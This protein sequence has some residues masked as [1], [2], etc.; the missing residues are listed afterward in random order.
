[1]IHLH[2]YLESAAARHGARDAVRESGGGSITYDGLHRLSDALRD[3]L[4]AMGVSPGDRVGVCIPKSIDTVAAIHGVLKSGGAYVPVDPHAPASRDAYI[5]S[6]CATKVVIVERSR[7][8]DLGQEMANLGHEPHLLVVDTAPAGQG[9]AIALATLTEQSPAPEAATH[10]PGPHDLAYI[11]Y[12]SGSTGKPK[13]VMISHRNA[14]SFVDWC[15]EEF[16]PVPDDVF[17]SHAPFHFDLSILD[18]YTPQTGGSALVLIPEDVGKSPGLLAELIADE[19]ITVWYSVPSILSMLA[20][21]GKLEQFDYSKVRIILFAGEVFAMAHLRA[22]KSLV[23]HPTY[24]NLYGPTE[25]NVCTFYRLPDELPADRTDPFPIGG[26]CPHLRGRVVDEN[27]V[28]VERG[29]EGELCMDGESVLLGYWNLPERTASAFL[30]DTGNV[31]W[32]RT[33]D[34]VTED[35]HGCYTYVGRRDRMVKKRGYRVELGEIES[36]LYGHPNVAEA[37]VVAVQDEEEGVRVIAHLAPKSECKLSVIAMKGYC[38][39]GLPMYMVPDIFRF[40]E[41]LPKT[42]TDKIDYQTLAREA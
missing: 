6:D 19:G 15:C 4:V 30:P 40:H 33:G 7:E 2:G 42:S 28:D 5:L 29:A 37:A 11:L 38:S 22:L 17:S 25:T 27:G 18:L 10:V 9:L 8:A 35:E 41:V 16:A 1:L 13:G 39:K 34:L 32:Y 26:S 23:P 3:R 14:P 31:R 20:L 24:Y 36:C 21:Y 12:T